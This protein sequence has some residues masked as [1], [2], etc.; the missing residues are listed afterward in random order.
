MRESGVSPY[1]LFEHRGCYFALDPERIVFV[2]LDALAYRL[3]QLL[4]SGATLMDDETIDYIKRYNSGLMISAAASETLSMVAIGFHRVW[5]GKMAYSGITILHCSTGVQSPICT[6]RA[7]A[8]APA[9]VKSVR[10]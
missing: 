4:Q 6:R 7:N 9:P 3:L 10:R 8:L 5:I 1:H 2:R